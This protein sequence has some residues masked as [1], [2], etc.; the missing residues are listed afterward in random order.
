MAGVWKLPLVLVVNDNQWA[1]SLPRARQTAAETLAQ[2]AIALGFEG[3]QVDGNDV[4]AVRQVVTEA[5]EKARAG[6]GPTLVEALCYRLC[7]HTTADDA[8]RYRDAESVNAA[9]RAEPVQRLRDYLA[10]TG[11]WNKEREEALMRE[12]AE[13]VARA[14]EAYERTPQPP[15]EHMFDHLYAVLPRALHEQRDAALKRARSAKGGHG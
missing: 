15:A 2:K 14:I 9:W 4:I 10:R 1:I 12:C 11:V 3:R 5:L 7:D 13:E 8:T 6:K